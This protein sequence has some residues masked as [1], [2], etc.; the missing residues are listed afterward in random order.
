MSPEAARRHFE[1]ELARWSQTGEVLEPHTTTRLPDVGY[2]RFTTG[3]VAGAGCFISPSS[4][5][6]IR[7]RTSA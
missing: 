6:K 7:S 1:E 4:L 5:S 2:Y 3:E